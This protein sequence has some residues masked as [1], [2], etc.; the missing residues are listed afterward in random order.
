MGQ[1]T[2]RCGS[3]SLKTLLDVIL[4]IFTGISRLSHSKNTVE[5]M[6]PCAGNLYGT[7]RDHFAVAKRRKNNSV[8]TS[9]NR[10]VSIADV[11]TCTL[12]L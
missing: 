4:L 1:Q 6:H 3:G 12:P 7:A 9:T 8:A 5:D 2:E 10:M 11:V